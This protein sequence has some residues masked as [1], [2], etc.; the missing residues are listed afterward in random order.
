M[1]L[2]DFHLRNPQSA[3]EKTAQGLET[4]TNPHAHNSQPVSSHPGNRIYTQVEGSFPPEIIQR[5]VPNMSQ[6]R[7]HPDES[8]PRTLVWDSSPQKEGVKKKK[9][10]Q[11]R[12]E[13]TIRGK[14]S[15]ERSQRVAAMMPKMKNARQRH[16]VMQELV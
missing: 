1:L 8:T 4:L 6:Y 16:A 9:R 10:A 14:R 13:Y 15:V 3:E 2:T 7:A 11:L 5:K 12:P